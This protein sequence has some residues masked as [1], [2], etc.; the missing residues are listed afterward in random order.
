MYYFF[1]KKDVFV[2]EFNSYTLVDLSV[3][4]LRRIP[5]LF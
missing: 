5:L 2:N 4:M 3:G 1:K